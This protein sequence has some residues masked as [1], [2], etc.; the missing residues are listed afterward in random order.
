[1]RL[2]IVIYGLFLCTPQLWAGETLDRVVASVNGHVILESDLDEELRYE[3][4]TSGRD[5]TEEERK[6]ALNRL[7]DRELVNEQAG[8][9]E[10]VQTTAEEIDKQL[11]QVESDYVQNT[12]Q[13]WR[14]ALASHGFTE[15]EIRDRIA[16]ELNQW[17]IVDARLRPTI[18]ID[19]GEVQ[20]YYNQKFLP[21]LQ[22]SG[23]QAI[24]LAEAAPKIHEILTQQK[25]NEALPSWLEA[26]RSPAQIRLFAPYS[27]ASDQ[28]R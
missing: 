1:M 5:L 28:A 27:S 22:R 11:A 10:Y 26:L 13:S 17:K 15:K 16:L 23:A 24:P 12:K 4:L 2:R 3:S 14:A 20:D 6:A 18:Q 8:T 7:I 19:N 25:M 9:T 21:E